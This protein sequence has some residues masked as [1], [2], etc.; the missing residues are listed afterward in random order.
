MKRVPT[1]GGTACGM[2]AKE[3]Y[4]HLMKLIDLYKA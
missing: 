4:E 1:G 2:A 3:R